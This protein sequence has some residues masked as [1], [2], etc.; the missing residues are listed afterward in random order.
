MD[1]HPDSIGFDDHTL[2]AHNKTS[3]HLKSTNSNI[4]GLKI[5]FLMTFV[6]FHKCNRYFIYFRRSRIE[7]GPFLSFFYLI[8]K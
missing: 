2:G 1:A 6:A 5:A 3:L 7:N 4:F 8:Q